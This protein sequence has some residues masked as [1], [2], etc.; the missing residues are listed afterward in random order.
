[1]ALCVCVCCAQE[2]YTQEE[3]RAAA[4][5]ANAVRL[6]SCVLCF[7]SVHQ[8]ISRSPLFFPFLSVRAAG[9]RV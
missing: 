8:P 9:V 4:A 6:A 7:V 1:M 3:L 2:T 5:A